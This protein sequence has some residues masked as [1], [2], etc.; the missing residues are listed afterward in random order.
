[1]PAV[2]YLYT[3]ILRLTVVRFPL[4]AMVKRAVFWKN[5]STLT[6]DEE[7]TG[8]IIPIMAVVTRT[9]AV[10]NPFVATKNMSIVRAH[11]RVVHAIKKNIAILIAMA[12]IVI[13]I[14]KSA[15]L[16]NTTIPA[17]VFIAL[18]I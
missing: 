14:P 3:H 11:G 12:I 8:R 4:I 9:M 7:E 16:L 17:D 10:G 18:G 6:T 5:M 1:M 2:Q 15:G 13:V